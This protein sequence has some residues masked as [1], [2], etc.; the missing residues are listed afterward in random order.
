MQVGELDILSEIPSFVENGKYIPP[1]YEVRCFCGK[2]FKANKYSIERGIK[3]DKTGTRSCGCLF[4]KIRETQTP[5]MKHG[6]VSKNKKIYTVWHAMM[7]RCYVPICKTYDRYGGRGITVCDEWHDVNTF[8]EWAVSNGHSD[9]LTLDRIDNDG[10]YDPSNCRFVSM[11]TQSINKSNNVNI[12]YNGEIK[13]ISQ[14]A[15]ILGITIP[16][17][18]RRIFIWKLTLEESFQP[19]AKKPFLNRKG[20][21][22]NP[23]IAVCIKNKLK[24]E[25]RKQNWVI[26]KLNKMGIVIKDY[27]FSLKING[28]DFFTLTELKGINKLL[29]TDFK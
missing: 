19:E 20:Y 18:H 24:Y 28:K 3:G 15:E 16:V 17:L 8:Y 11:K 27:E 22:M 14:W 4:K 6:V 21:V 9:R 7:T 25:G 23:D 5:N 13:T 12:E 1:K 29:G 10:N 26:G 2:I